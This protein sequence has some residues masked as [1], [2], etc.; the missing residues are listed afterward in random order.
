M[1]SMAA[2]SMPPPAPSGPGAP[3]LASSLPAGAGC[4]PPDA[5]A[6]AVDV[7]ELPPMGLAHAGRYAASYI[8]NTGPVA[9]A[10][11]AAPHGGRASC[12]HGPRPGGVGSRP[13]RVRHAPNSRRPRPRPSAPLPAPCARDAPAGPAAGRRRLRAARSPATLKSAPPRRPPC[14]PEDDCCHGRGNSSLHA[15]CAARRWAARDGRL[16]HR[17]GIRPGA[18]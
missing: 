4:L 3:G 5:A 7:I 13:R 17:K 14:E 1:A 6:A 15:G 10:D 2:S 18:R 12:E 9:G 16:R 11:R 8:V